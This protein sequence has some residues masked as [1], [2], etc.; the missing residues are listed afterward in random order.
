MLLP[1]KYKVKWTEIAQRRQR[2]MI[3]NN[4]RE[5]RSRIPHEY[6]IGSKVLLTDSRKVRLKLDKP[7]NGPYTVLAVYNNGTI[8]IRKGHV[9]QTVNI[10]R[11]TPCD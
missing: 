11:L 5:N 9:T 6:E 4:E 10:R 1:I 8:K 2:E 7:R 3:K